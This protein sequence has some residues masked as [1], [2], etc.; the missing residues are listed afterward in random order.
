MMISAFASA[1]REHTTLTASKVSAPT[2]GDRPSRP[3]SAASAS[4][5]RLRIVLLLTA[6]YMLVEV[7]GGIVTGSLALIADAGHMATDAAGVTMAL[8]AIWFASR[9]PT[10]EKSFGFYRIEILATIAN[11]VLLFGV[12]AFILYE[13]Y[14]RFIDPPEVLGLPMFLVASVGWS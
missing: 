4:A 6:G 8:I 5:S 2:A 9:P 10:K 14:R 12:A 3:Q 1:S 11:G 7:A 13:A